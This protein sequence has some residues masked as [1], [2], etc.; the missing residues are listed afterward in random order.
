MSIA[1]QP[2]ET[3]DVLIVGA[4]LSG[5]GAACWLTREAP[6][7]AWAIVEA[8]EALGGT[9][10]LFRYPGVRSDS[11]LY[12]FGYDFKPWTSPN[13]IAGAEEILA[14]LREAADEHGVTPKI[15]FRRRLLRA[16][17]SS[18]EA[19]WTVRLRHEEDGSESVLRARWLFGATGYYDYA[20]GHR[21]AFP[22]EADFAGPILHPQFWPEAFDAAGK[23]IAVIG[24]GATAVTLVPALAET[25]AHVVQVQR[26]PTYVL[27]MPSGDPLA[28]LFRRLLPAKTAH[29]LARRKNIARQ[30]W[31]WLLCQKYPQT[32]RRIIRW[33]NRKSLPAGYDVDRHF[34][35]PYGPWDQRLCAVPDGDFFEAIKAG[36]ASVVTGALERI[37]P[38]GLRMADGTEIEADV[39]VAATG[40]KLKLF[41]GAVL[42]V[43]GA[44]VDPAQR[45]VFKGM[46]LD[47][48]PNFCFAVGY[49]NASWTLKVGL[50]CEHFCRLLAHMDATGA[51]VCTPVRPEGEI[52]TRPLLD[53]KAGYVLRALDALPRQGDRAPWEMTFNYHADEKLLR[54]GP[55]DDP[56]LRFEPAPA[57]PRAEERAA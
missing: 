51:A 17:W 54:R 46:M 37:T 42:S 29:A 10:D 38:A 53:F 11:D 44:P 33:A 5:I 1:T 15:R 12:T 3:L 21:P 19:L 32:A 24:S 25:A 6:S 31:V 45:L 39:I 35:P 23:R 20:E 16:D 55:V 13:A 26:T 50:L 47:G 52:D 48:V 40:L 43:D 36:R 34:N 14:Y 49:T 2:V 27:P 8:R 18:A 4:G 28:N 56:A 7:K 57:G 22:G 9:W 30:R 41:G